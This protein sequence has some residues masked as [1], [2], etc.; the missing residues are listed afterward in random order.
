MNYLNML[1]VCVCKLSCV[2]VDLAK[3]MFFVYGCE[4]YVI[5][6]VN[7]LIFHTDMTMM[8]IYTT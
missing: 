3:L 5:A 1:P 7:R 8:V 6:N 4:M 2:N